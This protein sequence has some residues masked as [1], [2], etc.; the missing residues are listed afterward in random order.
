[1]TKIIYEM[2]DGQSV[3]IEAEDGDSV[4]FTAVQQGVAGIDGDCGGV[5]S[6]ATCHVYVDPAWADKLPPPS[7]DEIDMLDAT[8]AER[9]PESRLSCQIEV[10]SSLEGLIVRIPEG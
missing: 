8:S 10:R 3:S 1:M 4:M 2:R 5:L 7:E 6:C 9:T